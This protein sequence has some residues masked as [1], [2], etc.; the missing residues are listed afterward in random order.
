MA[1]PCVWKL[2]S[3]PTRWSGVGQF[4]RRSLLNCTSALIAG[5]I[6]VK[7]VTDWATLVE[8]ALPS[9]GINDA[10]LLFGGSPQAVPERYLERSP[11][12]YAEQVRAPILAIG[13]QSDPRTPA[14][15]IERYEAR[16]R[17]LGKSIEVVWFEEGHY[18]GSREQMIAQQAR[19]L[20][21]TRQV[22]TGQNGDG[23]SS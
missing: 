21:F 15:Q 10:A 6:A 18:N 12:T 5:G 11:I 22:A 23:Q 8:E 3:E 13:G 19:M 7:P 2:T 1:L 20:E 14:S 16:L 9:I 17:E 4:S